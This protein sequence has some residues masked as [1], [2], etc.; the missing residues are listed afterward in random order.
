M[1]QKI[2]SLLQS[3][4]DVNYNL[5]IGLAKSQNIDIS[6]FFLSLEKLYKFLYKNDKKFAIMSPIDFK[7]FLL[8]KNVR[9]HTSDVGNI[10]EIPEELFLLTHLQ[11][12]SVEFQPINSIPNEISKLTKLKR[13]TLID[14]KLNKIPKQLKN[15]HNLEDLNITQSNLTEISSEDCEIL[16]SLPNLNQINLKFNKINVINSSFWKIQS[17]YVFFGCNRIMEIKIISNSNIMFL[18]LSHN[19]I[20]KLPNNINKLFNLVSLELSNN[21]ID[22]LPENI[23]KLNKLKTLSINQNKLVNLPNNIG[24]LKL[25]TNLSANNNNIKKLPKSIGLLTNIMEMWFNNN[26]LTTLPKEL[27]NCKKLERFYA[28][29]NNVIFQTDEFGNCSNFILNKQ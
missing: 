11:S 18:D 3:G 14:T 8:T 21:N 12:L 23:T 2:I 28:Y 22:K 10:F 15:L 9:L 29:D 16:L 26:N 13:L 24:Q 20:D 27:K 4:N 7:V 5:G 1:K 6:D 19:N 17:N 25:L